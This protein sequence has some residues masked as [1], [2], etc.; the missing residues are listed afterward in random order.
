[1]VILCYSW[2]F[3][4]Q[5]PLLLNQPEGL[6]S[7]STSNSNSNIKGSSGMG[8]QAWS[9]RLCDIGG[10][11]QIHQPESPLKS[12]SHSEAPFNLFQAPLT[13][14]LGSLLWSS[15]LQNSL[16]SVKI[17]KSWWIPA[18]LSECKSSSLDKVSWLSYVYSGNPLKGGIFILRQIPIYWFSFVA[19]TPHVIHIEDPTCHATSDT[20]HQTRRFCSTAHSVVTWMMIYTVQSTSWGSSAPLPWLGETFW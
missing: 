2:D 18:S 5:V 3:Q 16:I 12:E 15:P 4:T 6:N 9:H 20:P 14:C 13:T 1:M 19:V 8:S 7:N 17:S 11:W 10:I